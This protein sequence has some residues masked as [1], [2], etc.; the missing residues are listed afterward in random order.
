MLPGASIKL[1]TI[2]D[3]PAIERV[4]SELFDNAIKTERAR[5]FINDPRHHLV[6]AHYA[7]K[8]I[9]M[10]SGFHYVHPDKDPALFVNE[11][12][13]LPEYQN[14][15]IGQ[16]LVRY[17]CHHGKTLG[18]T[19][20]WVATEKTNISARKSYIAAGGSEAK[21]T[22]VLIEFKLVD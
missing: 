14:K 21:E 20:A 2:Q 22:I 16:E 5:E 4:G 11:V 9:G 19:E 8:I 17:I 18:C 1:A 3:L 6:L 12:G 7:D 13:V 10:A 15:G